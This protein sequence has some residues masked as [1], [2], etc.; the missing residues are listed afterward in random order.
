MVLAITRVSK[1]ALEDHLSRENEPLEHRFNFWEN[2]PPKGDC[3]ERCLKFEYEN[4]PQ[5]SGLQVLS[6]VDG[7]Q[8]SD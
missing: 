4:L 6:L 5:A 7:I 2:Q 1:W 3:S 8:G